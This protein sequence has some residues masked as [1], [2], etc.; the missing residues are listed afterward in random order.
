[1]FQST[2]KVVIKSNML[3]YMWTQQEKTH[4]M[5]TIHVDTKKEKTDI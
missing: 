5:Y 3:L 4:M 1:V 2:V